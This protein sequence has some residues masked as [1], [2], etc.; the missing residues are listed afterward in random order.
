M[1]SRLKNAA[2][3]VWRVT[4]S[5]VLPTIISVGRMISSAG[6]T[7]FILPKFFQ[8][9]AI[10]L[11][12]FQKWMGKDEAKINDYVTYALIGCT[13]VINLSTRVPRIYAQFNPSQ[14]ADP[15][16]EE[17]IELGKTGTSIYLTLRCL[18]YLSAGFTLLVSYLNAM[19]FIEFLSA[20]FNTNP[21]ASD[22]EYF[23]QSDAILLA[24]CAT[25]T[26]AIYSFR[27]AAPNSKITAKNLENLT[28]P[29]D[30]YALITLA[31]SGVGTMTVPF[32]NFFS[33]ESAL[34]KIPITLTKTIKYIVASFSATSGLASHL[35]T[36][37]PAVYNSLSEDK[38]MIRYA[39][40]PCWNKPV[41]VMVYG[42]GVGDFTATA[43]SN[44]T[45]T[46]NTCH[47]VIGIPERHPALI[48]CSIVGA[49][50]TAALNFFFSVYEGLKDTMKQY[51][52]SHRE[53]VYEA[54]PQEDVVDLDKQEDTSL[55]IEEDDNDISVEDLTVIIHHPGT[56]ALA[57]PNPNQL[58]FKPTGAETDP[59]RRRV[60]YTD[61]SLSQ[62]V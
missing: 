49:N 38:N 47:N 24:F 18:N 60:E 8:L 2:K 42:A 7:L 21:H 39:Q 37:I 22:A 31:I 56:Q 61:Y 20:K 16:P 10:L 46:L 1:L 48:A 62:S 51:Q 53:I 52:E 5:V 19:T 9:L 17:Q 36:Q 59:P 6:Q 25:A 58:L 41:K 34:G 4:K 15:V 54:M 29:H 27:K 35:M 11:P 43:I 12:Q 40:E 57:I 30:K 3:S 26:Y 33:T 23:T 13:V 28:I 14:F 44:F 45:G 50:S 32:L 55:F